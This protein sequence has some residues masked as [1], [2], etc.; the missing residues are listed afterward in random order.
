MSAAVIWATVIGTALTNIVLRLTPIAVLSRLRMPRPI[1][2][3]LSYVPV[4]V[5]AAIVST[6]VLRPG[7]HLIAPWANP[8]LLAA[9]PTAF[10]YRFTRSLFGATVAGVLA[11][12]AMR[13]L[14]G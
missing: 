3:W 13:Y 9:I 5:M 14:L 2:R 12:L 1:E 7:G 4:C 8:Y 10:V 11:F 6:E